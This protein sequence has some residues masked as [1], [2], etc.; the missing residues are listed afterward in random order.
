MARRK[1]K[2]G[3]SGLNNN[4][5]FLLLAGAGLLWWFLRGKKDAR[6]PSKGADPSSGDYVRSGAY[7]VTGSDGNPL[8]QFQLPGKSADNS[9]GQPWSEVRECVEKEARRRG[10]SMISSS[11]DRTYVETAVK[12]YPGIDA[13]CIVFY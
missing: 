11:D 12:Q 2:H 8:E 10:L 1:R 3:L 4:G 9:Y 7:V 6:K 13:G 5:T